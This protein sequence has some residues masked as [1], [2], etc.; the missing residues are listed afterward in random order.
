MERHWLPI[1]HLDFWSYCEFNFAFS[2]TS[3]WLVND[4]LMSKNGV[5]GCAPGVI[6]G[7]FSIG[8]RLMLMWTKSMVDELLGAWVAR[9][10][11]TSMK[12]LEYFKDTFV[13]FCSLT[14][15]HEKRKEGNHFFLNSWKIIFYW[16]LEA[17]KL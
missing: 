12:G 14:S 15:F 11:R 2:K 1:S 9:R 3:E 16:E 10:L 5:E 6:T 17:K 7:L 13:I 4:T 8:L